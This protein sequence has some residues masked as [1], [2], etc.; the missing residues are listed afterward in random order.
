MA[1]KMSP[2]VSPEESPWR[3][4]VRV[5]TGGWWHEFEITAKEVSNDA[6]FLCFE[7]EDGTWSFFGAGTL[8]FAYP[9]GSHDVTDMGGMLQ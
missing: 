6:G 7:H 5:G 3:W 2:E 1:P 9:K 8:A 4:I